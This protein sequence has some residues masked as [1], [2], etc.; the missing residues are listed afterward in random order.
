MAVSAA[1][2]DSYRGIGID[3]QKWS[4]PRYLGLPEYYQSIE[5]GLPRYYQ[6]GARGAQS[7]ELSALLEE[8]EDSLPAAAG[9]ELEQVLK[10]AAEL[11]GKGLATSFDAA[12]LP[13][14]RRMLV[15]FWAHSRDLA[16]VMNALGYPSPLEGRHDIHEWVSAA[17]LKKSALARYQASPPLHKPAPW[18]LSWLEEHP[19][20]AQIDVGLF[21]PRLLADIYR[22]KPGDPQNRYQD[23]AD[24]HIRV[25]HHQADGG[26]AW[27]PVE[28]AVNWVHHRREHLWGPRKS[29]Q[30][31]WAQ[32]RKYL[33]DSQK[34][35]PGML[36]RDI[37]L[38]AVKT[39]ERL[40]RLGC[41]TPWHLVKT[42]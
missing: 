12:E 19:D 23:A 3:K 6:P 26:G 34:A 2:S 14:L 15:L 10:E 13:Q 36:W 1:V 37:A 27:A 29:A 38:D 5:E 22:W 9:R 4:I 32:M 21:N 41:C 40:E 39:L 16:T 28:A 17:A 42:S 25:G 24:A 7:L 18:Y 33:T 8:V 20:H 31:S 11:G 30:Q 35:G